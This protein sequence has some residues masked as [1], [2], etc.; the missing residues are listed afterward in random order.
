[1]TIY[2]KQTRVASQESHLLKEKLRTELATEI[3]FHSFYS[4][5][6]IMNGKGLSF[7]KSEA[8]KRK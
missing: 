1:M 5:G 6:Q 3:I 2:S 8:H 7:S 4:A